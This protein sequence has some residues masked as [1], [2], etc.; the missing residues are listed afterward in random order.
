MPGQR[1]GHAAGFAANREVKLKHCRALPAIFA[2]NAAPMAEFA[3]HF[4]VAGR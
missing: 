3:I 4:G 2:C 1:R